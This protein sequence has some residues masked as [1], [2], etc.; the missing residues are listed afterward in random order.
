MPG[1]ARSLNKTQAGHKEGRLLSRLVM[2]DWG[3]LLGVRT[4][5]APVRSAAQANTG[6]LASMSC[7]WKPDLDDVLWSCQMA[8]QCEGGEY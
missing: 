4:C 5:R 2:H 7:P 3:M 1:S 6:L 8:L